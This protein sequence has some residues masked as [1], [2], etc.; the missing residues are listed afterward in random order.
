MERKGFAWAGVV[1]VLVLL[2]YVVPY[3]V[4]S[5][6]D[7]WYGAFLFWVVFGALAIAVIALITSS[8]RD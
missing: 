2:A 1:L 3:T 8:W 4:L 7:A 6:V 5:G